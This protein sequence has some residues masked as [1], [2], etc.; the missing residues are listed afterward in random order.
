MRVL[1]FG[2]SITQG[3]WDTEGGWAQRLRRYYDERSV[4][5]IEHGDDYPDIFNLGVSGD[6][7]ADLL[8]RFDLE[9]STRIKK[10]KD[11]GIVFSIGTNNAYVEGDIKWA[12]P[13]NYEEDLQTLVDKARSYTSKIMFVGLLPC[14]EA[15]TTPVFWRDIYYTN[16]R[17]KRIDSLMEKVAR[18]NDVAYVPIFESIKNKMDT[19][20][21]L[22][23][24]GLHPNNE[25]HEL[26][27][28]LVRP[29]LD[30]L[31]RSK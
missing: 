2:A 15:K 11:C 24:D 28:Q 27:F 22:Y 30:K 13:G 1:I 12:G 25:G 16:E 23:A 8:E 31:I 17:I 10:G 20:A 5:N 9:A 6:K 18:D 21:Q 3:F 29:E 14:E 4:K 19:G 26:I 7:V